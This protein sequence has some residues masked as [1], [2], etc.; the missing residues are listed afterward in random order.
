MKTIFSVTKASRGTG[1][2]GGEI[3]PYP[4]KVYENKVLS[5]NY[6]QSLWVYRKLG[7]R[8]LAFAVQRGNCRSWILFIE[9]AC[10]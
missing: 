8:S 7:A 6:F 4:R 3:P 9:E 2:T 10:Y 5:E 1:G